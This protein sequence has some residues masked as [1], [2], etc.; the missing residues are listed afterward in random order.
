VGAQHPTYAWDLAGSGAVVLTVLD[1]S[2]AS[3]HFPTGLLGSYAVYDADQRTFRAEI[4]LDGDGPMRLALG[5]GRY[6]IQHRRPAH[7]DVADLELAEG[8]SHTLDHDA[9]TAVAYADDLA[10]GDIARRARAARRPDLSLH[11]AAG[12]RAFADA[13]VTTAYL[14]DTLGMGLAARWRWHRGAWLG[15]DALAGQSSGQVE[16]L[17]ATYALDSRG[18]TL[19]VA[20]GMG[21]RRRVVSMAGGGRLAGVWLSREFDEPGVPTQS[22][23]TLTPGIVARAGLHPGPIDVEL[24]LRAHHLPYTVDAYDRGLTF[25]EALLT[26]GVQLP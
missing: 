8:E 15:A 3:L 25:S 12:V 13:G 9:F 10:K 22:L 17:G 11:I 4:S 5:P 1:A 18:T 14:P 6:Q 16:I 2:A 7:L 23:F 26:L 21:T 24:E 19:G 20:G